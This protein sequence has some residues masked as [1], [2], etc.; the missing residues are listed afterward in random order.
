MAADRYDAPKREKHWQ[1]AW[2]QRGIFRAS[3]DDPRPQILCS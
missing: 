2:E 3:E 1:A